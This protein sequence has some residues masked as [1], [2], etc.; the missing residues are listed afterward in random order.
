LPNWSAFCSQIAGLRI[1]RGCWF[2]SRREGL[3]ACE[4]DIRN[5]SYILLTLVG[6]ILT[7][8]CANIANLLLARAAAR[9]REI[10]VRLS[11]GAGRL[12]VVR[13]LL[14]ESVLLALLG[15]GLGTAFAVWGIRSLTMLLANG[16]ENFT[17][18]ADLNWH[19]L[20]VVAALSLLTG[21]LFGLV[22]ALQATKVDL[23][24]SLKESRTGEGGSRRLC[25]LSLS[26]VLIV[27]QLAITMV[28]LVAA[29]L[30][31]R[32]LL[33][34]QSIEP[35]FNRE[36]VLTFQLNAPQAGHREADAVGF[37]GDLQRRLATIPGVLSA[38]LSNHSLIGD[39]S[40]FTGVRLPGCDEKASQILTV[41]SGF[42]TTD[43]D[44]GSKRTRYRGAGPSGGASGSDGE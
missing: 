16:R 43:A 8:A 5:H 26:R 30:F 11:S 3:T 35:G 33:N 20:G 18:R 19:V 37:Y 38:S 42:F 36:N 15:G 22:P 13:Q 29:G 32:T 23:I 25:A 10:A 6:L 41:G 9:R 34:R 24:S 1:G 27:S 17:L 28:I 31:V 2:G 7:I 39:G 12:R 14:T 21:V 40:S 44:S 4:G